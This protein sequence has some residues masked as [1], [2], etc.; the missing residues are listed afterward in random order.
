MEFWKI[1]K[2]CHLGNNDQILLVKQIPF[3]RHI[4]VHR[5]RQK[6]VQF[7]FFQKSLTAITNLNIKKKKT[8]NTKSLSFSRRITPF[9]NFRDKIKLKKI[10]FLYTIFF[11]SFKFTSQFTVKKKEKFRILLIIFLGLEKKSFSAVV[12]KEIPRKRM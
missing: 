3:W 7:S 6:K 5:L 9:D 1:Y 10:L 2:I 11:S 8:K 4:A 12:Y